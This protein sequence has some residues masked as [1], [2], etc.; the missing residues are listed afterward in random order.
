LRY[1]E[2]LERSLIYQGLKHYF[3]VEF[4]QRPGALRD[5]LSNVLGENNNITF[6]EYVKR[7]NKERG[8]AFIGIE[9]KEKGDIESLISRMKASGFLFEEVTSD[10]PLFGLII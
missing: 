10:S 5:Y 1:P 3:I 8:P 7:N 6:F 2:I 9:V 4:P